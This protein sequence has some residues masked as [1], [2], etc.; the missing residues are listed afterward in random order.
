MPIAR[1]CESDRIL[2]KIVP[3][4]DDFEEFS[5]LGKSFKTSLELTVGSHYTNNVMCLNKS[6]VHMPCLLRVQA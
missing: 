4:R 3:F 6:H 2:R 1:V 5:E